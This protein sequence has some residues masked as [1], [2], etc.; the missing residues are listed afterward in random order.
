MSP[1]TLRAGAAGLVLTPAIGGS[2]A[3]YWRETATTPIEWLRPAATDAVSRRDVYGMAA[4]PLVPYSN[5]IRE[6]RFAF[7]GRE[8]RLPLNC[9]PLPH[10]IHGHGWQAGWHPVAVD[11]AQAELEY[12]HP[13]DTWPWAYR[14]RQRFTLS[15]ARLTVDLILTNEGEATMPA[16]LGWHPYFGRTPRATLGAEVT[17]L[18]LTDREVMPTALAAPPPGSDPARGIHPDAVVLDHC[19]T[20][21]SR[22]VV[23][24]WPEREARLAMTAESPLDFLVLYT[25]AGESFFCAEPVSHV[26]DAFNLAAAGRADT[27]LRTLDPGESLAATITLTP[28]SV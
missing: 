4:F 19:F 24:E 28:E 22:R 20:G 25:P 17:G 5:R 6:G 14:A 9:P 3:R 18:W 10:S 21:W 2:I 8:V 15:A 1:I 11:A 26:T 12:R 7:R 27:G 13:A 23:V 16:G